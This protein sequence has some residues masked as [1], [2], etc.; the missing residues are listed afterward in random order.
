MGRVSRWEGAQGVEWELG[1]GASL[2]LEL[3]LFTHSLVNDAQR[4]IFHLLPVGADLV[5]VGPRACRIRG[6]GSS[7]ILGLK[8]DI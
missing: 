8:M 6:R 7:L 4:A 1:T 5:S 3:V 2:Q